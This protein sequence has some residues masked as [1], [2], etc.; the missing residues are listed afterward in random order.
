MKQ[1]SNKNTYSDLSAANSNRTNSIWF[2]FTLLFVVLDYTRVFQLL[3]LGF[4]RPL[5]FNALI[6]IFFILIGGGFFKAKSK[7]TTYIL[8]FV[9]LLAAH[10]PFAIN[11]FYAYLAFL[12]MILYVPFILST[13]TCIDSIHRLRKT[14]L[15]LICVEIYIAIYAFTHAGC[16]PSN[17]FADE[18]DLSLY[19]NMW[20][21]FCFFL[22][23]TQKKLI[24][25]IICITGL[26]I[27]LLSIVVSFSRGGFVGLVAMTCVVWLFSSKK[28][29]SLLMI[30]LLVGLMYMFADEKYWT[31]MS[32]TIQIEEGTAKGR[33]ETWKASW[34]MFL[35][36]PLGVGGN[37]FQV[38]FP[39]Y[40]TTHFKRGMWGRVAHSLWFTLLPELGILGIYLYFSLLYYNLKDIFIL[41]KINFEDGDE[42]KKFLNYV[43]RAFIASLVGFFASATFLSVLYYAH[44]WYLTGLIVA[45]SN[46]AKNHSTQN[47]FD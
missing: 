9:V 42:D 37:N 20:L 26:V 12:G 35:N 27:G 4:L 7:Q 5:M 22:F 40:Q 1:T 25:K 21:P 32:T 14:I 28:I 13:I 33:I 6:L 45:T 16:G 34:R 15:I 41:K 46:I 43:G 18:N 11:N 19:I 8:L 30:V 36:N 23:F 2:F 29:L 44:Y 3:H 24:G 10:V 47:S 17:Y 39:K 38:L 31:E